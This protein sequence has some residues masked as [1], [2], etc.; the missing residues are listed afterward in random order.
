[1]VW[2]EVQQGII[3]VLFE[4]LMAEMGEDFG[5]PHCTRFND[6]YDKVDI[7]SRIRL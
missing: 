5:K 1:M 3:G 2:K 4:Y 7:K 6:V